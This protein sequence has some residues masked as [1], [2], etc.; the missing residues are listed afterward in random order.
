[1]SSKR[2][3]GLGSL[4]P[5]AE[6]VEEGRPDL[7]PI[8]AI[9]VNPY[10]PRRVFAPEA[11]N[12][13]ADSIKQYGILQ[14]LTVRRRDGGFELIAGERRLQ[15]SGKAGLTEVPVLVRECSDE[16]ML[17]LALVENLQREDLNPME[18]ARSY[19][20]LTEEFGLSQT[21]V[22]ERVGKNRSTVANTMRLLALPDPIQ[23]AVGEGKLSEG[24]A[25][26]LLAV[27]DAGRQQELFAATVKKGLSVRV[28]ES[29]VN[30]TPRSTSRG[31]LKKDEL[32]A[33]LQQVQIDLQMALGVKVRFTP[34]ATVDGGSVQIDYYSADDLDRI[35]DALR[36]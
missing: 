32:D 2:R 34:G 12:E 20:Q 18:A 35:Y 19:A 28:L 30:P 36:R 25:R 17:A 8:T 31:K 14:P 3:S 24:H 22:A 1:M 10:Q 16:E 7:V 15:A 13:L 9:S 6:L 21:E 4:I 23:S 11:L 26:A 29:M 33:N 27:D 5:G